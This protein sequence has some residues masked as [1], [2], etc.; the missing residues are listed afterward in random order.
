[1]IHMIVHTHICSKTGFRK[2]IMSVNV[3]GTLMEL[4]SS[5][6]LLSTVSGKWWGET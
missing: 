5:L 1:M 4:N 3:W 2:I 6:Y